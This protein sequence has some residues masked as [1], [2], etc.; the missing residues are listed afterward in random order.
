MGLVAFQENNRENITVVEQLK[1]DIF[2]FSLKE[3]REA[4][5]Q[6]TSLKRVVNEIDVLIKEYE[7]ALGETDELCEVMKHVEYEHDRLQAKQQLV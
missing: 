1:K 4:G 6:T 3:T 2:A 5:I 7:S